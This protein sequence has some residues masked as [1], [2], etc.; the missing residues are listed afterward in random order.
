MCQID[1]EGIQGHTGEQRV[2][3]RVKQVV[4]EEMKVNSAGLSRLPPLFNVLIMCGP[5]V[6]G[7]NS[8]NITSR[9]AT[10]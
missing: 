7:S 6:R 5:D 2:L 10:T 4:R 1:R 9:L 8:C 3:Q